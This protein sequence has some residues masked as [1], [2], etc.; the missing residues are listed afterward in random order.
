MFASRTN[1]P[2]DVVFPP[3]GVYVLESHHGRQFRMPVTRHDFLKVLYV[4][5]GSGTVELKEG[6]RPIGKGDVVVIPPD[7]PH[8]IRDAPREALALIVLCLRRNALSAI[9]GSLPDLGRMAVLRN[10]ALGREVDR[11]LRQ[12][13]FEQSLS[14]PA[15]AGMMTGLA[16]QLLASIARAGRQ[17]STDAPSATDP[18]S[19]AEARVRGYLQEL[20]QRYFENEKIDNVAERLGMSRRSFTGLFRR[21]AGKTWLHYVRDLRIQHAKALLRSADRSILWIAYECGFEDLTTFYRAFRSA[22]GRSPL[23]WR[24]AARRVTARRGK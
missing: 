12:L 13:F 20:D 23:E 21:V 24:K 1:R 11:L 9:S 15:C 5:Q 6:T 4:L 17:R 19:T 14:R 8:A 16:F 7:L 18:R 10:Y 2:L 22:E 3:W